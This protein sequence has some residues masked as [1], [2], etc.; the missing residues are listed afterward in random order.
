MVLNQ[1]TRWHRSLRRT[2]S[3]SAPSHPRILCFPFWSFLI[4]LT[5]HIYTNTPQSSRFSAILASTHTSTTSKP[6]ADP[7]T[8]PARPTARTTRALPPRIPSAIY[9][10]SASS[11]G[12]SFFLFRSKSQIYGIEGGCEAGRGWVESVQR[13]AGMMR[14]DEGRRTQ[15]YRGF[16]AACAACSIRDATSI[17]LAPAVTR[18]FWVLEYGSGAVDVLAAGWGAIGPACDCRVEELRDHVYSTVCQG[19]ITARLHTPAPSPIQKHP[20]RFWPPLLVARAARKNTALPHPS[21]RDETWRVPVESAVFAL[22]SYV[23]LGE[24]D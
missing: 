21:S 11:P 15:E 9:S 13:D 20:T 14:R 5:L 18:R 19:F 2:P 7:A 22:S 3:F 16:A 17:S 24:P 8:H 1:I 10:P 4:P 6:R 12:A 23:V